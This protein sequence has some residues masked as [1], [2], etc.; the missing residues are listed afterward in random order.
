MLESKRVI[1]EFRSQQIGLVADEEPE[2]W[3]TGQQG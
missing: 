3:K 1:T 2:N